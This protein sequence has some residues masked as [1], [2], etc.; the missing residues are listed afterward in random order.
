MR[1]K[2]VTKLLVAL[3]PAEASTSVK[4]SSGGQQTLLD[5]SEVPE[6]ADYV[7]IIMH[8][9]LPQDRMVWVTSVPV[10][11]LI[12]VVIQTM[13]SESDVFPCY[14]YN[15]CRCLLVPSPLCAAPQFQ[16]RYH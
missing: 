5:F 10:A 2:F 9:K 3:G 16:A 13:L 8:K 11:F 14:K 7:K 6:K 1:V 12:S 15:Y 4:T